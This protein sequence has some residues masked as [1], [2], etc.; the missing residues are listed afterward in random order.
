MQKGF[1][2][3]TISQIH[4]GQVRCVNLGLAAKILCNIFLLG[5][6]KITQSEIFCLC[7]TL[8]F[9]VMSVVCVGAITVFNVKVCARLYWHGEKLNLFI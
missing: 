6:K 4:A 3:R 1:Q 8:E 7:L 9:T 2:G 5:E